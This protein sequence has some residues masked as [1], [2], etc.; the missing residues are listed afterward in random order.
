MSING[1][2]TDSY[3]GES[4][5]ERMRKITDKNAANAFQAAYAKKW[6]AQRIIFQES[7]RHTA[8][9]K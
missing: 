4:Y 8:Q 9:E 5:E 2:G 6:R 3:M 7:A 1:I